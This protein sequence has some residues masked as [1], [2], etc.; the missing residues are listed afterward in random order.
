MNRRCFLSVCATGLT[1]RRAFP[2]HNLWAD[3]VKKLCRDYLA[4]FGSPAT[5]VCY[6]H[7][8]NG[9]RGLGALEKPEQI[10]KAM[11]NGQPKPFGSGSGIQDVPLEN[12]QLLFA[13]CDACEAT[14]DEELAKTARWI[15]AGLK[16]VASVSQ[17]PGFVPR[18]PHP[19]GKSYY[20]DSSRDQH[21]AYI[22]ALWRFGRSPLATA[23]DKAFIVGTQA[24]IA[25]RM[26]RND[27]VLKVEDN[28]CQAHVGYTWKQFTLFGACSLMS[29]LA[30]ARD[31]TGDKHWAELRE[32]L[33]AEKDGLR[34][35]L[36]SPDT[37]E[38]CRP[39]TL[40]SNQFC[41]S[42][43]LIARAERDA[44]RAVAVRTLMKTMAERALR[45]N[46]FDEACWR[47][48]D[49]A[50]ESVT[51]AHEKALAGF[52]LSI[53]QPAT[54]FDLLAK[55]DPKQ[56]VTTDR[57]VKAVN[58]KLL[59]GIPTVAFHKALLSGDAALV[60]EVAPHVRRMVH[61]MLEHGHR[62]D[63]GENFNR[64]V[65]LGLHLLS[66]EASRSS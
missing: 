7:R 2:A 39:F 27:W 52:G 36:L 55:F 64:A 58:E 48:L 9:P 14:R 37:P 11:V 13:L 17:E 20:P 8:L 53:Q 54:V 59:F 33:A 12:G 26:E 43:V 42:L 49:W 47:R 31:A 22:E 57:F 35:K 46:V 41:T 4:G 51:P 25:R 23:D 28:S 29:C 32:Q 30:A 56:L 6:H 16:R 62:Y 61:V 19:D 18:G 66:V 63:G 3:D 45:T 34:W 44:A 40:Y 21:C 10:A 15:F 60:R 38:K 24:K 5:Q 1:A 65:I 50:G